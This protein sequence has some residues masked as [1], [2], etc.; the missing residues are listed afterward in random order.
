MFRTVSAEC[1]RRSPF[2]LLCVLQAEPDPENLLIPHR[3]TAS[4][5]FRRNEIRR[6]GVAMEVHFVCKNG[7]GP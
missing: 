5:I 3:S 2:S 1:Q 6:P 4:L 7:C